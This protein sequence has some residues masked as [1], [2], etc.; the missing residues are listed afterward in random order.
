MISI[1]PLNR[2]FGSTQPPRHR[3]FAAATETI[4]EEVR[5]V[6]MEK[7]SQEL[8]AQRPTTATNTRRLG[9]GQHMLVPTRS[10]EEIKS[11][12]ARNVKKAVGF[13]FLKNYRLDKVRSIYEQHL[14]KDLAQLKNEVGEVALDLQSYGKKRGSKMMK[15]AAAEVPVLYQHLTRLETMDIRRRTFEG[16]YGVLASQAAS[17][18]GIVTDKIEDH[19]GVVLVGI[20][21]KPRKRIGKDGETDLYKEFIDPKG[22]H[23][24]TGE[25]L[26]LGDVWYDQKLNRIAIC[27]LNEQ[28]TGLYWTKMPDLS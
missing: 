11:S 17:I 10:E 23:P 8:T 15:E 19:N 16:D 9:E 13:R 24:V 4:V 7:R 26:K 1:G 27:V 22:K 18:R 3:E 25:P 20:D 2:Q 6:A 14:S 21:G 12:S 28:R 5:Q